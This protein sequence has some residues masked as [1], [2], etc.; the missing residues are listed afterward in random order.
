MGANP[1]GAIYGTVTVGALL[2][3]E[4]AQRETYGRTIGAVALAMALYWLA[5]A[6]ASSVEGRLREGKA[7][8]AD[9]IARTMAREVTILLGAAV[10]LLVVVAFGV[11]GA[12]LA[13]AVSAGVWT[14]A[15]VIVTLEAVSAQ[16]AE[17][18]G[19]ELATQIVVGALLGV[20]VI[21]LKLVLH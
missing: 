13:T 12:A 6:Y 14:S 19:R 9:G 10:P 18:K 7:L 8:T 2:A 15:G 16:R 20:L 4:R 1:A 17:L 5:H 3:A 21:V 11:F